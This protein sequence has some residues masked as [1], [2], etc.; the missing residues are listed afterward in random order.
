MKLTVAICT[1][2]RAPLLRQTLERM[3]ELEAPPGVDWE[4]LVVNNRCTDDTDAVLAAFAGRLP[5]RRLYEERA[6]K[7]FACNLAIAEATGE[8]ILWTDD[9]VLVDPRWMIEYL[10]A[11]RRHPDSSIFGGL[12]QPWFE[13]T[14]PAWLEQGFAPVAGAYAALDLGPAELPLTFDRYPYG[15][16]MAIRRAAHLRMPFDTAIGPRPGSGLRGEEMM[17]VRALLEVG[18]TG[19]WVP[20]ASVRHYI[21]RHR[22]SVRYLREYFQGAGRLLA[23]VGQPK[24]AARVFGRP[25]WMWRQAV[26]NEL[27]YRLWRPTRHALHWVPRLRDASVA[28]G[29]LRWTRAAGE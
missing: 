13:G 26:E 1:W 21:P 20:Q 7:S 17:L 12:I 6:G 4:L 15:A 8:Y 27:L 22:Q 3:T 25:A 11:F 5:L 2:N 23:Y 14:P 10:A 28:W 19:W 29:Q 18:E 9:D 24:G 16:N